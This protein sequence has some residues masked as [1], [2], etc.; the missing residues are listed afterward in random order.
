MSR[1]VHLSAT[2]RFPH[3]LGR[4]AIRALAVQVCAELGREFV[5]AVDPQNQDRALYGQ[6]SLQSKNHL[7]ITD[8]DAGFELGL[9]ADV[10]YR[11]VTITSRTWPNCA[12]EIDSDAERFAELETY[13]QRFDSAV[14]RAAG[15]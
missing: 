12:C 4:D 8:P 10:T 7:V 1:L 9:A 2:I 14:L 15:Y 6:I 3:P 5:E 13:S 11:S